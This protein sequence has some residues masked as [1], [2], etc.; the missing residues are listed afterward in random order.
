MPDPSSTVKGT[1]KDSNEFLGKKMGLVYPKNLRF[2]CVK[3]GLCCG[4]TGEKTR[5]VLLMGNEAAEIASFTK[6]SVADFA[7]EVKGQE[8]Y[9]YEMKKSSHEGK[10]FFLKEN[11]CT[12]YLKRPLICRFYPF[13][14]ETRQNEKVFFFTSECPGVGEGKVMQAMD[15][16]GLLELVNARLAGNASWQS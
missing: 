15:F 6:R 8:P 7:V 9:V 1:E 11:R 16:K 5:H 12:I 2:K 13:W 3:C 4:D 14:L 10:C